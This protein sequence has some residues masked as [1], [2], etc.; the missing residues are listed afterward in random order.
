MV[1]RIKADSAGCKPLYLD[2]SDL[3][4]EINYSQDKEYEPSNLLKVRLS[5]SEPAFL[6][7]IMDDGEAY[8]Y[9]HGLTGE[10]EVS[11]Y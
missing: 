7:V 4:L 5:E 6:E 3:T 1:N 8:L 9:E 10:V 2:A 11:V